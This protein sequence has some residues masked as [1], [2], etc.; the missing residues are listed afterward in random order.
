MSTA[1]TF[2]SYYRTYLAYFADPYISTTLYLWAGASTV[3]S[4][5]KFGT[6]FDN[7]HGVAR[8]Y[9]KDNGLIVRVETGNNRV[10]EAPL[11]TLSVFRID[12]RV[13]ALRIKVNNSNLVMRLDRAV[14][15][16]VDLICAIL[17]PSVDS[18][19]L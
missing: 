6:F 10:F 3:L 18:I 13:S 17:N 14:Y 12:K 15:T 8:M 11:T 5:Y 2:Y 19:Q 9:L 4:L 7:H 1:A 16:D